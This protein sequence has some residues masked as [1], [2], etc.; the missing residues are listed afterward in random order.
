MIDRIGT[1][2]DGTRRIRYLTRHIRIHR[3]RVVSFSEVRMVEILLLLFG[4]EP[5]VNPSS[6]KRGL[7][8]L[9]VSIEYTDTYIHRM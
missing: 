9:V 3:K 1:G 5:C 4:F 6:D 8:T 7:H 2:V